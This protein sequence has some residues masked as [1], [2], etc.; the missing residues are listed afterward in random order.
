MPNHIHAILRLTRPIPAA[1]RGAASS[2]PTT[3]KPAIAYPTL[4]EVI[5]AFKSL[6]AIEV[7]R[8]LRRH[9]QPIWQRNYYERI[10]RSDEEFHQARSYILENPIRWER[11]AENVQ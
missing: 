8:I 11:D 10:I 3:E 1:T 9:G 7:N 5:R 2:A 6:T 4:G